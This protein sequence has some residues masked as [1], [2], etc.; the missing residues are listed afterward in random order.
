MSPLHLR[1]VEVTYT[2]YTSFIEILFRCLKIFLFRDFMGKFREMPEI[3]I[4]SGCSKKFQTLE[5]EHI[6]Y[7]FESHDQEILNM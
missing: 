6:V 7:N 4:I 1:R 3:S 2:N 5:Y